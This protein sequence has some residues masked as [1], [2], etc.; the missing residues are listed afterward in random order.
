MY[1]IKH[2][3]K[4]NETYHFNIRLDQTFYRKSLKT[5]SPSKCRAYL[6]DIVCF[7]KN[8]AEK[9]ETV[10]KEELDDFIKMLISNKVNELGRLGKAI[11]QPLSST[12]EHYF[13]TWYKQNEEAIN[14]CFKLK[15]IDYPVPAEFI[16]TYISYKEWMSEQ[17]IKAS[18]K[19][20]SF[21]HIAKYDN[22]NGEWEITNNMLHDVFNYPSVFKEKSD[23]LHTQLKEH[24]KKLATANSADHSIKFRMELEELYKKFDITPPA[25]LNKIP[26]PAPPSLAP[27]IS[28]LEGSVHDYWA[29]STKLNDKSTIDKYKGILKDII[30]YFEDIHVDEVTFHDLEEFWLV[31]STL[32]KLNIGVAERKNYGFFISKEN[33]GS[34]EERKLRFAIIEQDEIEINETHLYGHEMIKSLKVVLKVLFNVCIREAYINT[35][36]AEQAELVIPKNKR[37]L[38]RR[39]LSNENTLK[40]IT[41]CLSNL[42]NI[43]SWPVLIMAYHGMRNKEVATLK[44]EDVI[45]DSNDKIWYFNITEGKTR[46]AVRKVPVHEKLLEHGFIEYYMK[47]KEGESLFGITSSMLT[48]NFNLYRELFDIPPL[49][50]AGE[51]QTLYSLRHGVITKLQTE[52]NEI[53]YSLIG[54]GSNSSTINYTDTYLPFAQQVINKVQ[55]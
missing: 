9:G 30:I 45:L 50:E 40:V 21:N 43:F 23:Y 54:H 35:N 25:P 47:V 5:D 17:L 4:R 26:K 42:D 36:P 15:N 51:L 55:Y 16:P 31:Y 48:N 10:S 11:A 52:S 2:V 29:K 24:G 37:V 14:E 18:K 33:K 20:N 13:Q 53:K 44:R 46:N 3:I 41:H 22:E 19:D 38:R 28:E 12:A 1:T 6:V 49:N 32:P 8:R 39:P 34:N 7:I 27:L